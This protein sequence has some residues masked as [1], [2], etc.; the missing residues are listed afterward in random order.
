MISPMHRTRSEST[1]IA[2]ARLCEEMTFWKRSVAVADVATL[3]SVFPK[4]IV[5]NNWRGRCN[6]LVMSCE[7]TDLSSLR[8]LRSMR[9]REKRAVSVPEKQ[10]E[11]TSKRIRSIR[12]SSDDGSSNRT[13]RLWRVT[14]APGGTE[15]RHSKTNLRKS[16]HSGDVYGEDNLSF[17]LPL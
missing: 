3:T 9:F 14:Q 16:G 4:R 5:D 10:P 7:R 13:S 8:R 2:A 12:R 17:S 11:Q 1:M 6:T 15:E